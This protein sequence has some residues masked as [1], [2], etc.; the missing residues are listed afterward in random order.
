[1]KV[2]DMPAY[3]AILGYDWLQQ[4]SP[5]QC[6]WAT[7]T[8]QFQLNGKSVI[9][10]GVQSPT[11]HIQEI[12]AQQV[13]KWATGNDIWAIAVVEAIPEPPPIAHQTA[14]Q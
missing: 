5:M 8:M 13:R 7:K 4:N 9:L 3:D 1:M 6:N 10:Q 11:N 12:S 14:V 2:L